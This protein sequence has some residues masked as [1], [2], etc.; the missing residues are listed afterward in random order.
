MIF[1]L[2][3]DMAKF[4]MTEGDGARIDYPI[5]YPKSVLVGGNK[6]ELSP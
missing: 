6:R 3:S 2:V 4:E 5:T 1:Y